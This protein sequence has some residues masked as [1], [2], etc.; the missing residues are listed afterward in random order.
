[1]V[2]KQPKTRKQ[3]VVIGEGTAPQQ[4]KGRE[5]VLLTDQETGQQ[6]IQMRVRADTMSER[7][8]AEARNVYRAAGGLE[9]GDNEA[10]PPGDRAR[11]QEE[12]AGTGEE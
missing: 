12:G 5:V 1:M 10:N 3:E 2:K 8:R 7:Q 11:S 6:T 9:T 4:G